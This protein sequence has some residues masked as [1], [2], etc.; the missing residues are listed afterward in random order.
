MSNECFEINFKPFSL[1]YNDHTFERPIHKNSEQSK[2][3]PLSRHPLLHDCTKS[4]RGNPVHI[5][6]YLSFFCL[7]LKSLHIYFIP[8]SCYKTAHTVPFQLYCI[9]QISKTLIKF[10]RMFG[11]QKQHFTSSM[12]STFVLE[13]TSHSSLAPYPLCLPRPRQLWIQKVV[14]NRI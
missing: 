13:F 9:L 10:K 6:G 5:D 8:W 2:H 14:S 4:T 3:Y 11:L 12:S 1:R 7:K